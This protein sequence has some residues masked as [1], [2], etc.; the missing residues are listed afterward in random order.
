M[1][2]SAFRVITALSYVAFARLYDRYDIVLGLELANRPD[3]RAKQAAG[4]MAWRTPMLLNLDPTMTIADAVHQIDSIRARNYPHR[5]FPVQEL[6][7]ELGITRK[8]YH[9]LFDVIINYI[10]ADYDFAFEDA[11]VEL[12]NLSYG[13]RLPWAV[14]IADT[15]AAH[16][17]AVTVDTDPG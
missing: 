16:D 5:H 1:G 2:S 17:L 6:A 10:P 8:G 14:T 15:G 13:F 4:L 12:T 11:A 9:G 3:A 7:R